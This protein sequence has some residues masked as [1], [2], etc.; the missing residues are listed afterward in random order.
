MRVPN[1]SVCY[2]ENVFSVSCT[3]EAEY[4]TVLL[5]DWSP[6]TLSCILFIPGSK[7]ISFAKEM[8]LLEVKII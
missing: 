7:V 8:V 2:F 1:F 3:S 5:S 6:W 4:S